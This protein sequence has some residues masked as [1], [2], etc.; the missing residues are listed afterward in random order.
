MDHLK[1][2]NE[3]KSIFE[4]LDSYNILVITHFQPLNLHQM[5][6]EKLQTHSSV[7]HGKIHILLK[8]IQSKPH[9]IPK[10]TTSINLKCDYCGKKITGEYE[11]LKIKNNRYYFCCTSCLANY[12]KWYEKNTSRLS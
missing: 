5:L 12:K 10:S 6:F 9:Q 7:K 8:E 2:F 1:S 3:I 4:L 11:S